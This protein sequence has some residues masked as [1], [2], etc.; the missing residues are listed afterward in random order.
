MSI[1]NSNNKLVIYE[2]DDNFD[3]IKSNVNKANANVVAVLE[4]SYLNEGKD[5]N[6]E[7]RTVKRIAEG[8]S[9]L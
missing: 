9:Y 7:L 5:K 6:T 3:E 1:A 4:E 2:G 8:K